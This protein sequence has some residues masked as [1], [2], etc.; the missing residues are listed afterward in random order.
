MPRMSVVVAAN[1]AMLM[2]LHGC[3]AIR[4]RASRADACAT[5]PHMTESPHWRQEG[6]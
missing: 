6:K 5:V 2:R 4:Q 3:G 1:V